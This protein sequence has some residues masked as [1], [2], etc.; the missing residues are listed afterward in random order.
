MKEAEHYRRRLETPIAT[1]GEKKDGRNIVIF[2]DNEGKI[3]ESTLYKKDK[4]LF[5]IWRKDLKRK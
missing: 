1:I 3:R 4:T 5:K 2:K